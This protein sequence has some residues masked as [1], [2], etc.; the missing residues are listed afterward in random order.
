MTESVKAGRRRRGG[1]ALVLPHHKNT[2]EWRTPI[3]FTLPAELQGETPLQNFE[4]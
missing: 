3:Q 1:L 2:K 4:D